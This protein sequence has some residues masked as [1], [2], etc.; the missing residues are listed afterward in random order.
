MMPF[1]ETLLGRR[2][3]AL[4]RFNIV[5]ERFEDCGSDRG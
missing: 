3:D 1:S 5:G 2:E 4:D